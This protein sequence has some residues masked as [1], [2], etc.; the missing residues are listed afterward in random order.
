MIKNTCSKRTGDVFFSS[1]ISV[2]VKHE[3]ASVKDGEFLFVSNNGCKCGHHLRAMVL[4]RML[5]N[6]RLEMQ[7][8]VYIYIY[9]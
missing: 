4:L 6:R 8:Y 9:I 1:L 2:L 5:L 3:V 7:E